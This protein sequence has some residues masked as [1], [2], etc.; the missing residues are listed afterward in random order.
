M[1]LRL[2]VQFS[3]EEYYQLCFFHAVQ[4]VNK[5]NKVDTNVDDFGEYGGCLICDKIRKESLHE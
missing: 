2:S 3:T 1:N 5:G 4:E